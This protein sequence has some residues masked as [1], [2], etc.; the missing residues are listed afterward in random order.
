QSYG[1]LLKGSGVLSNHSVLLMRSGKLTIADWSHNGRCH[2]WRDGKMEAPKL[3][4]RRYGRDDLIGNSDNGGQA[5]YGSE[6]GTWQRQ[7]EAYNCLL[8]VLKHLSA[9][10]VGFRQ[11]SRRNSHGSYP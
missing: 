6:Q 5:H 11:R 1:N 10:L 2:I 3:Y 8:D 7:I 4:Q 9:G